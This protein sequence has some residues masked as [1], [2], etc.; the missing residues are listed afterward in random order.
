VVSGLEPK[1]RKVARVTFGVP[2]T[3]PQLPD[4]FVKYPG[5]EHGFKGAALAAS[6]DSAVE[7]LSKNLK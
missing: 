5:E 3:G 4:H 7:F 2:P 1:G 6:R